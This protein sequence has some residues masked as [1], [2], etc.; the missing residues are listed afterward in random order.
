MNDTPRGKTRIHPPL[1]EK[2]GD[3]NTDGYNFGRWI[4]QNGALLWGM[5]VMYPAGLQAFCQ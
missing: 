1:W 2:T 3:L 4:G 5:S